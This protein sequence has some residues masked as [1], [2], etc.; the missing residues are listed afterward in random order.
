MIKI[1]KA[2]LD[3]LEEQYPGIVEQVMSFE[4]AELPDCS[5]C[6][7]KDTAIVDIGVI[8]RTISIASATSKFKLIL[9]APKPGNYF[10]ND[11][12]KYFD[13]IGN[14]GKE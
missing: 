6:G 13:D 2:K 10:C 5:Y 11:C 9:N 1:S 3:S 14:N 4:S 12:N 8:G 7:S